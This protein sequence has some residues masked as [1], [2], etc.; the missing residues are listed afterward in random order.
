MSELAIES[1]PTDAEQTRHQLGCITRLAPWHAANT[2]QALLACLLACIGL[3]SYK[4]SK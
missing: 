4:D 2:Y 1:D 3:A